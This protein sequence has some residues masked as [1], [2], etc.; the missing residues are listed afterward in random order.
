MCFADF[1]SLYS[2][3]S[4]SYFG[5]END[6]FDEEENEESATLV[7]ALNNNMGFIKKRKTP[8][9]IRY[10]KSNKHNNSEKYFQNIMT[11]YFPH[12]K[13]NPTYYNYSTFTEMFSD[14]CDAIVPNM[15]RYEKISE[16]LDEA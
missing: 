6:S 8:A 10:F 1:A 9:V 11:V 2:T 12:R 3:S 13:L 4:G 15:K 16:E 14:K 5:I 7:H